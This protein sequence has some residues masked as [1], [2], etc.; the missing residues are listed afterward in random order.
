[1]KR[2]NWLKKFSVLSIVACLLFTMLPVPFLA[3]NNEKGVKA[4]V[5]D[6]ATLPEGVIYISTTYDL[7][8][9]AEN[10]VD[11]QWS[12]GKIF[13]LNN[14]IHMTGVDFDGIPSFGG[15]FLGQGHVIYG[16]DLS[17]DRN[18][19]GFFRYIQKNA[20]VK[21]L[22][23]EA[24]VQ[25]DSG[26][27]IIGGFAG[28]NKGYIQDCTFTGIVSGKHTVGGFVGVNKVSGTIENCVINGIVHGESTVGGFAGKNQGVIRN[29]I[30]YAEINTDVEHNTIGLDLDSLSMDIE[31]SLDM[32]TS[33]FG[34]SESMDSACDIGGVAG[35]SSG[36]IRSCINFGNVGYEKMGY[37]IGGIVGSQNGY[38]ADCMNFAVINGA[39]GVGGIIGQFKPNVQLNFDNSSMDAVTNSVDNLSTSMDSF[40]SEVESLE[41]EVDDEEVEDIKSALEE[42][43][44]V[45]DAEDLENWAENSGLFDEYKD[46]EDVE[47]L[48]DWEF[49]EDL[50]D[51][52]D[53]ELPEDLEELEDIELPEELEKFED[54]DTEKFDRDKLD[55]TLNDLSNSFDNVT[56]AMDDVTESMKSL[57][58]NTDMEIKDI[59]RQDTENDTVAK[60][61]NCINCGSVFGSK[62]VGGIAGNANSEATMD[63]DEDVEINGEVG[64]NGEG[65]QR[66]VIRDCKNFG[67]ISVTKK[68]A[69]GIVGYMKI[70]AVF[71]SKNAGNID[72]LSADYI[73]GIAGG[74]D[75]VIF[76]SVNKNIIAGSDYVG[77]IAG[78]GYE[79]YDSC[80]F[81]DIAAGTKYVGTIFGSTEVLPTD[82]EESLV[83]NNTYYI[84]GKNIGGID[85]INYT[86]ASK[87]I[88]L[89]EFLA[90]ENLDDMFKTVTIRFVA[91]NDEDVV[92]TLNLGETLA[93]GNVPVPTVAE[94]E[95]Y[96]W[97]YNKPVTSKVLGMNEVEET[98]YLSE[99][100]LTG[101]LFNQTYEADFNPKHMV[102]QGQDKTMDGKTRVLA[103]GAFDMMT[104]VVLTNML[105]EEAVVLGKSVVENWKVEIS[106]IGVK[107]LRYCIPTEMDA[108]N[109]V[110][111]VKDAEGKWAERDVAVIG[112]YLAFDF[113]DGDQGFA[114]YEKTSVSGVVVIAA[115]IAVIGI[116]AA[117]VIRKKKSTKLT[118]VNE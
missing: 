28:C 9:L 47:D 15:I 40:I 61:Y 54:I 104:D 19:T 117:V 30:N 27:S 71:N 4:G 94:G 7:V 89:E 43:E 78:W 13:V 64:I 118:N 113:V 25:P 49:P 45:E 102:A 101:V 106:N 86:G 60:A 96:E 8:E 21:G 72:A 37:N 76:N 93:L 33:S 95:T 10:C 11:E 18:T 83:K 46:I 22:K 107:E 111:F 65:T 69:G 34:F 53:I 92:L 48:E 55:A 116:V 16:L 6:P 98:L 87:R 41:S 85:G 67:K 79:V 100:K 80:A 58:I 59:S 81:V 109:I 103:I 3:D 97:V 42:L 17:L 5:I 2:N 20:L 35:T 108:E 38:V 44:D 99:E 114:L 56:N 91:E 82:A 105:S 74:C 1:M 68:Y 73:G 66:L 50:E 52:E 26:N 57:D 77:G 63:M 36:V 115:V 70:G 23:I 51:L 24:N 90:K 29:C 112:S 110:V 39:N 84:V 14:D 88:T 31:L 12:Q 75:T 32:D 62:Y